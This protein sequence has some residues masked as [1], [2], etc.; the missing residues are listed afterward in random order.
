MVEQSAQGGAASRTAAPIESV[1]VDPIEHGLSSS[2]ADMPYTAGRSSWDEHAGHFAANLQ[3]QISRRA[4][5][6]AEQRGFAPGN[7][8]E[9]WLRAERE[10]LSAPEL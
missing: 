8:V 7:E 6:L 3:E 9:D 10:I 2:F 5:E 4:Y 1:I